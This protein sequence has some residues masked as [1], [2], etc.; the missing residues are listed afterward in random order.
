MKLDITKAFDSVSW[1]FLLEVMRNLGFGPIWCDMISGLLASSS[2]QILLNGSPG[3]R[4]VHQRGLRQ[5]DPLSPMLFILVMDVLSH[6][7]TKASD[8]QLL[9]PLARRALQHR[10][11]LYADD[12][13]IF[14]RP[15]ASDIEI[16]LDILQLFGEASGLK[17][18]V[19]KSSVLPI[20]CTEEDKL[21]LQEHLP[22][23]ISE[24]PCKYLGVPLSPLKLTKAQIQPII[25]KIGDRLPGWK[26]DLLT[27]AGRKVLV[28]SVLTSMLIYLV[29]ALDL[30]QWALKA[31]DKIRR[32]FLWRGRKDAR[33]GHCL[34]AWPKVTRPPNLGGLGISNLQ[35]LSWALRIRWLWLQ[36]TEPGKP[37]AFFSIQ[38]PP[39][40][41][42]FL[43]IAI[44]TEVGNGKNTSFW[45]DRWLLGQSLAQALP[46]LFSSVAPRARKR[47]VHAALSD[48]SWITD[49]K[50][51]LTLQVLIEY[52]QLWDL[53]SNFQL[54][55]DVEDVH[56][57]QFSA[58]SQYL[59]KSAYEALFI[60]ATGF[61][62][63]ERIWRSWAPG[64]CKFFMWT[65]AH[66]RCWTA[67]R[68]A[69]RGLPH[70]ATCPL[71]DQAEE[72]IDHLMISCVLSRQFWFNILQ[73]FGLDV[74]APQ[75][76]DSC[77]DD[78]WANS[79]D[80]VT[81]QVKKGLNSI[82]ILGAWSLWIHRNHCVFYGGTPNL[83]TIVS[84]FKEEVRQWA[85]AGARGVSHLLALAPPV[86]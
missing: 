69:R 86:S 21:V 13:V 76:N 10:I 78:W 19:Q 47:T 3:E 54:Q 38:A 37:W 23:Q 64:K 79:S 12:V 75:P 43:S 53:L 83:A 45:T 62:P 59:T 36:K 66:N 60:G 67:D 7:I 49:I 48:R 20:Q 58:S 55:P 74:L 77:F 17:T 46:H 16:T 32:G 73:L 5:G 6:L 33:G 26:A 18:N 25:E 28:Q 84:A 85:L 15:S 63:W 14:L 35:N 2:T 61:R 39:Q 42:A 29:M 72:T 57:W 71:C 65:V 34:L 50:G 30:P 9:Q 1:P 80:K 82:I 51:A 40:I 31:I 68:L 70:P 52:L 4:I 41:K 8:E 27:K 56:I 81:G 11:S 22:C 44:V 24:F